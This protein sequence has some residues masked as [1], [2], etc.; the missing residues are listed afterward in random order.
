MQTKAY[1][2]A[3]PYMVKGCAA[4]RRP[5]AVKDVVAYVEKGNITPALE[6]QSPIK[7]PALEQITVEVGSGLRSAPAGARSTTRT[8]RSRPSSWVSRAGSSAGTLLGAPA[9]TLRAGCG[10]QPEI[11]MR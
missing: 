9:R 7:G 1:P 11:L 2:P 8:S 4:G 6:F 5:Q 10:A 3:G